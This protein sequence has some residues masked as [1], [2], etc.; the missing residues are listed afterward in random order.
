MNRQKEDAWREAKRRCRL[1]EEEARMAKELG[2]QPKSLMKN[3]PSPSQPWKAPV[4]EWVRS[5]YE[6]KIGSRGPRGAAPVPAAPAVL[7]P[8]GEERRNAGDPWPD[9]PHIPYLPPLDLDAED[10]YN[11]FDFFDPPNDDE[12]DEQEGLLLRRQRLFR[13]AAQVIAIA[14][15][16]LP[17][18]QKLAAFGAAS[19][20]LR[21]EEPRLRK[22]RRHA[23]DLPHECADLDLA[24]WLTDLSRLKSL[25]NA[26][27][28]GL[29]LTQD[30]PYGG[31]A[32]QQVDMHV[33]DFANGEYGAACALLGNVPSLESANATSRVAEHNRFCNSSVTMASTPCGSPGSPK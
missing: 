21:R 23:I 29:A 25:K 32:H 18:V 20:P 7:A 24:V 6:K 3:I 26:M 16:E 11:E 15:S 33:F 19:Q 27:A 8:V 2:F 17:E 30:T 10:P 5:L 13:W 1:N 14:L 9:N 12:I 4:N 22:F 28:R 31:V